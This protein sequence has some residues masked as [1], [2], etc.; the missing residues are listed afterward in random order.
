MAKTRLSSAKR[1]DRYKKYQGEQYTGM[2]VGGTHK[3]YYDKGE[4][5]ERKLTPDDWQ[6]YYKTPKRRAGTAPDESGVPVGTEYNWLIVSHQRVTKLDANTY[7]TCMEGRKFKVAHKRAGKD[8][9]SASEKT[10]R[11]H[12]IAYLEQ[13]IN[14]IKATDEDAMLPW[15]VG[16]EERVYG[17]ELRNLNELRDMAGELK[18]AGRS[19]MKR[20]ELLAAVHGKLYGGDQREKADVVSLNQVIRDERHKIVKK[21]A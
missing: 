1:Y 7:M 14:E 12:V 13:L 18:I 9:W 3:W 21:A 19:K 11:K 15:T 17:L 16:D 5:R 8:T 20:E 6:I 10:Q 4:W 2:K